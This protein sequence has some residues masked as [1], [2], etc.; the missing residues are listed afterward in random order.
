[1]VIVSWLIGLYY[2]VV[3]SHVLYFLYSSFTSELPWSS[4]N[5][6]WNTELC[7]TA[8]TNGVKNSKFQN[9]VL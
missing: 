9:C 7:L 5:N 4:C 8:D 2:N 6:P 3:I 1:M